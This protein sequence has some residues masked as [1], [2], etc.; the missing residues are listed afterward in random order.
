MNRMPLRRSVSRLLRHGAWPLIVAVAA[1]SCGGGGGGVRVQTTPSAQASAPRANQ[2][3]IG[4]WNL[5]GLE[6]QRDGQLVPRL[7]TGELTYDEFANI[8]VRVELAP[9][10]PGVT[11][12]RV[13]LLDFTAK[14]SPDPGSGELAYI[15]LQPRTSS[16]R[17]LPDAVPPAEWRHFELQGDQL[18]LSVEEGGRPVGTL[19][20][21][22]AGR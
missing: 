14:A 19:I 6:V 18:R 3:M 12:P 11:P 15:G 1:T 4:R 22:R 9:S 17:L 8:S 16:D 13:V 2:Q 21:Q 5:V 20:F 7:A 10:D